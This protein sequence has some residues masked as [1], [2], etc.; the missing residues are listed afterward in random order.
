M[1]PFNFT[2]SFSEV[3]L[4]L[5]GCALLVQLGLASY[6]AI[7]LRAAAKDR[8]LINKELFGLVK[9]IEGLTSHRREAVLRHYDRMLETLSFR[10]PT[11]VA[12]QASHAILDAESKILTRLAELEPDLSNDSVAKRKMDEIVR[13]LEGLEQ[14][15]VLLTSETVR[16]VM[17]EGR[18]TLVDERYYSDSRNRDAA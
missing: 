13:S 2:Y 14:T 15:L 10:I 5:M 1:Q 17:L 4:I 12:S 3:L 7:N 9:K 8:H 18:T 16:R 6:M 11:T